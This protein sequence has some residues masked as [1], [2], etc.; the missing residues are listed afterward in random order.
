MKVAILC[1]KSEFTRKQQEKLSSLGEV[2]YTESREEYPLEELKKL[3]EGSEIL[4]AD[5]DNLGGF[6]KAKERL[7]ELMESLPELKGVALASTS[8]SWI[9]LD[10]CRERSIVVTNVPHYS[11]E[12]VA[13]HVLGVLIC[14]AKKIIISDR[15]TQK[16]EY[17]LD[18]GFELKG[19]TLGI[20][21]L[22]DIG[23]RVTELANG[24]GMN[25]LAYNRSPKQ[26]NNVQMKSL[27]EVLSESDAISINVALNGE[28]HHLI[29]EE[30][31][32][33]LKEGV[34]IANLAVR[35]IV[36]ESAMAEVLKSGRVASYAFEGEDLGTGPL[37]DIETAIALKPFAWYTRE[38]LD[39]AAEIWT[40]SILSIAK[41]NPVNKVS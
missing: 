38:A 5:P 30:E 13:E 20:I 34:I 29:S 25:V 40:K 36:D 2:V 31:L 35:E 16:G 7:T 12:S 1:P 3:S 33:K 8:Y 18:M 21:G 22:G 24:I 11:T 41:G 27:D 17:R 4:G 37:A 28:T 10:Y 6:E 14:L 39:R 32:S 26:M 15:R 23:S 19:K 9:D